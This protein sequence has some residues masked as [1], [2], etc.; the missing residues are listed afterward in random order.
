VTESAAWNFRELGKAGGLALILVGF[1]LFGSFWTMMQEPM[2]EARSRQ[3]DA[4]YKGMVSK[5][6]YEAHAQQMDQLI[7]KRTKA[8]N[9]GSI[10]T[11]AYFIG[12]LGMMFRAKFG[13]LLI[14]AGTPFKIWSS[15][16]S[17]QLFMGYHAVI[18]ILVISVFV[19]WRK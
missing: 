7:E 12:F 1:S 14:A 2:I 8:A 15:S 4:Q 6:K 10:G 18:L 9:I 17:T 5:E 11:I 16:L 3:V 13:P 19:R